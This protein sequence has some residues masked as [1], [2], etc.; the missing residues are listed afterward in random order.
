MST[1]RW[2]SVLA[3][4]GAAICGA[5]SGLT[6]AHAQGPT[7]IEK[8]ALYRG[9]DREAILVEGARKEGVVVFYT[10]MIVDQAVRPLVNAFEKKYPFL[11]VQYV[12]E[13]PSPMTQKL[14]SEARANRNIADV[15]E[16]IGM[17]VPLRAADVNR[18][19]WSPELEFFPEQFRKPAVYGAPSRYNYFGLAYNTQQVAPSDV[20]KT[21]EDILNPKWKGKIAWSNSISGWALM[22]TNVRQTMGEEKGTKFIEELSKQNVALIASSPRTVVDRVIAGE[23][24]LALNIFIH[25]P[26]LSA[27]KGAPVASQPLSPVPSILGMVMLPKNPPHPHAAM[28]FIDFLLSKEGQ[29]VLRD[30]EYFPGRPDVAPISDLDPLVP[31]KAGVAENYISQE[32][33][34]ADLPKARELFQKYFQK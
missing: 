10:G 11:K 22:F 27:K 13:D 23:Y 24:A 16:N 21:Y 17:D 31:A 6:P 18:E 32:A 7:A 1:F 30:A 4:L 33:S 29:S 3:L 26:V 20:P 25:H 15:I 5:L 9:A 14:I 8:L 28:L 34:T 2:F 19:F 12:R